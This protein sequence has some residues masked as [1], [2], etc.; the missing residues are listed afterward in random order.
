MAFFLQNLEAIEILIN[1]VYERVMKSKFLRMTRHF[2]L[3]ALSKKFRDRQYFVFFYLEKK[4][5][6][7]K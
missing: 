6:L 3:K 1:R 5:K 7:P 4:L 2:T